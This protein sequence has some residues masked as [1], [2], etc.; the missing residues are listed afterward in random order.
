MQG[1]QQRGR[2][3]RSAAR[4]V[5]GLCLLALI[6]IFVFM[7]RAWG[8]GCIIAH[9]FGQVGGTGDD[10]SRWK[11]GPAVPATAFIQN[12]KVVGRVWGEMRQPSF[13][14]RI[15]W[16]LGNHEGAPPQAVEDN[17]HVKEK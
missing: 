17:L 5:I 1:C 3:V 8:Q 14:H 16:L 13:E 11:L 9:S 4:N 12:G 15:E 6:G 2:S 7:P 10:V